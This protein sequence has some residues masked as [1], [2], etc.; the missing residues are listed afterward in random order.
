MLPGGSISWMTEMVRVRASATDFR[1]TV[2]SRRRRTDLENRGNTS[3]GRHRAKRD[4]FVRFRGNTR[5]GK[6][7]RE[8]RFGKI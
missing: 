8:A 1:V 6:A 7:S 2:A 5:S 4:I 3:L